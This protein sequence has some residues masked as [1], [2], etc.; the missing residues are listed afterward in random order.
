MK[1]LTILAIVI[2]AILPLFSSC[3]S[4]SKPEGKPFDE[5]PAVEKSDILAFFKAIPASDLP[6]MIKSEEARE[7]YFKKFVFMQT[8]GALG[9]GDG[10]YERPSTDNVVFWSDYLEELAGTEM[11]EGN[12]NTPHPYANFYVY[13]GVESGKFFGLLK[14]GAFIGGGEKEEP[15]KYY[16]FDS[17]SGKI[18]PAELPLNP[19][20]SVDDLTADPLMTYGSA[21]LYYAIKEGVFNYHYDKGFEVYIE[22]VGRTGVIYN[23][24]GV[25]FVRS[26][27]R[28][29]CIFNWGF[30][31]FDLGFKIPYDIPGYSTNFVRATE[32]EHSYALVKSGE[33]EPTL[34]LTATNNDEVFLIEVCSSDY[35]NPYGIYPG[36][37]LTD[38]LKI[39]NGICES[40][41]EE[42]PFVTYDEGEDFVT[43][44]ARMDEDFCY[45]VSKSQYLGN[46][47]FTS[48]ATI[49]RVC[50]MNAVG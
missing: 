8:D 16:W 33:S 2:A 5:L 30:A 37:P 13:A 23:W 14:A 6:D 1:R 7:I 42:Q 20:Y 25:E 31:N 9:D 12:E 18:T 45:K 47:Q 22:E 3:K 38:F 17:T 29:P 4:S 35:S 26:K 11:E 28:I 36:M 34:V 48:D 32:Y 10:L 40:Y 46:E 39:V 27:E 44:Y 21:N 50:V 49:A 43:I 15:V 19:P 24:D 41:M